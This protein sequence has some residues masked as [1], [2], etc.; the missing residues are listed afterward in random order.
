MNHQQELETKYETAA[1]PRTLR[2]E[3][4][5][6]AYEEGHAYGLRLH[7]MSHA[8]GHLKRSDRPR[9]HAHKVWDDLVT[10]GLASRQE[11]NSATGGDCVYK[12]TE[13]GFKVLTNHRAALL[14]DVKAATDRLRRAF[15]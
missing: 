5:R 11:G 12:L 8:V 15:S 10:R 14:A 2:D 3:M 13:A 1:L 6:R 7:M 4:Y 9:A